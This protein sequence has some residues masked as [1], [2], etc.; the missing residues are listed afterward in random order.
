MAIDPVRLSDWLRKAMLSPKLPPIRQIELCHAFASGEMKTAQVW[1]WAENEPKPKIEEMIHDVTSGA[2]GYA[3]GI[4]DGTVRFM[5]QAYHGSDH[6]PWGTKFP[7]FLIA[8]SP[9]AETAQYG[10]SEPATGSGLLS[11]LMRHLERR[12]DMLGKM[13]ESHQ[14]FMGKALGDANTKIEIFE[15]RHF[16]TIKLYEDLLDRKHERELTAVYRGREDERKSKIWSLVMSLGPMI[17][18]KFLDPRLIAALPSQVTDGGPAMMLIRQLTKSIGNEQLPALT[19]AL[20]P[21]QVMMLMELHRIVSD[22]VDR[23]AQKEHEQRNV[24]PASAEAMRAEKA[25]EEAW[26]AEQARKAAAG[27]SDE[28]AKEV[29]VEV[30]PEIVIPPEDPDESEADAWARSQREIVDAIA[31]DAPSVAEGKAVKSAKKASKQ[32]KKP[33]KKGKKS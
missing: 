31:P 14:R 20:N 25:A 33:A 27:E 11:Q 7:F 8:R 6:T 26:Y 2:E 13:F 22:E 32:S 18:S 30:E 19:Q 28:P 17:V 21:E 1:D 16:D 12:E 23:D 24:V 4:S 10:Q 29:V 5:L 3:N 15:T 9:E